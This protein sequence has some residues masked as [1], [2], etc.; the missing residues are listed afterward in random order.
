MKPNRSIILIAALIML[1]S[2]ATIKHGAKQ[3]IPVNSMPEGAKVFVD[4]AYVGMTPTVIKVKRRLNH[5]V[6]VSM[7][8]HE[9]GVYELEPKMS[10][11]VLYNILLFPGVFAGFLVD[12]MTGG[13]YAQNQ[14]EISHRLVV[15]MDTPQVQ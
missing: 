6:A 13:I 8:G 14:D 9:I 3:K 15:Q 1:A 10:V 11:D 7:P 4:G 2:C 5:K 12:S